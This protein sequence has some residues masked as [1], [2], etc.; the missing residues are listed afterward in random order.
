[1]VLS[2]TTP[3]P[4]KTSAGFPDAHSRLIK[5]L[6]RPTATDLHD[7][8]A[9]PLARSA[10]LQISPALIPSPFN[11]NPGDT[12]KK[13][14]W[15]WVIGALVLT[16]VGIVIA[17]AF[18]V[19]ARRQL[20]T[21]GQLAGNG[22][23]PGVLRRVLFLQGTLTG[24][25]GSVAGVGLGALAL[26]LLAPYTDQIFRRDVHPY[27]VRPFDVVPILLLGIVTATVAALVPARAASRVPVLAALA[28]RRPLGRVPRWLPVAGAFVAAG[29]LAL[30]GLA[31][32]GT[33]GTN[34]RSTVW[35]LTAML[36]SVSVLLGAC[37]IAPFYVSVLEPAAARARGSW[38]VATRSLA[39][40]RTRTSAVVSAIAATGAFAIAVSSLFL[41]AHY[42][43]TSKAQ[44]GPTRC[45]SP[46]WARASATAA[47]PARF[48][49]D[50][51]KVL[52]HSTRFQIRIPYRPNASW[53]F[54]RFVPDHSSGKSTLALFGPGAYFTVGIA[55]RAAIAAYGLSN[56][57]QQELAKHGSLVLTTVA[58]PRHACARYPR[59]AEGGR[60]RTAHPRHGDGR[61]SQVPHRNAAQRSRDPG[62]GGEARH[63]DPTEHARAARESCVDHR[64]AQHDRR[65]RHRGARCRGDHEQR[66]RDRLVQLSALLPADRHRSTAARVAA[67]GRRARCSPSSSWLSTLPSPPPRHATNVMC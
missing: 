9:G 43:T 66:S 1:M 6:E 48:V 15:S 23:A 22:A 62:D 50:V 5:F 55:D 24:V 7:L 26:A 61:R 37:A 10:G 60:A 59:R 14:A 67:R 8:L 65:H 44:S 27:I 45:S 17:A 57:D 13:V 12:S 2:P 29:G 38:R 32:F 49:A 4:W 42:R 34:G 46:E 41:S 21:L 16:V 28:G 19:G 63:D 33:R 39:R 56:A 52:P 54:T 20:V 35:I 18:A 53:S 3:Y 47:P 11:S 25:I 40:Q 30:L 36:G 31:V 64:P 51:A 58:W